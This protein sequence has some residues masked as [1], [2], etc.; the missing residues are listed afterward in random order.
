MPSVCWRL[1]SCIGSLTA[2]CHS[3][4]SSRTAPIIGALLPMWLTMS[5]TH[6]SLHPPLHSCMSPW[7][8]SWS[9]CL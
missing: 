6:S 4:T 1:N 7:L 3:S 9:V 8:S 2:P 5:I